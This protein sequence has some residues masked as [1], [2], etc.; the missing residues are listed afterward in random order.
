[1]QQETRSN[2][3]YICNVDELIHKLLVYYAI[4]TVV[5]KRKRDLQNS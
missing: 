5:C 4:K 2:N 3:N 1:M